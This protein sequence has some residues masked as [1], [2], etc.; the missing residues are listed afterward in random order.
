MAYQKLE[1]HYQQ[2]AVAVGNGFHQ[3]SVDGRSGGTQCSMNGSLESFKGYM[4][5]SNKGGW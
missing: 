4:G 5:V 1:L 3:G 2:T